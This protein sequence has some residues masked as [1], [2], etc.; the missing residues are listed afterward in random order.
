M[1]LVHLKKSVMTVHLREI[2][3]DGPSTNKAA[4]VGLG[5]ILLGP[6]VLP[7]VAKGGRAVTKAVIKTGL[8]LKRQE[9]KGKRQQ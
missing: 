4:L 6:L 7:T 1:S 8:S 3:E 9:E 2:V 5:A